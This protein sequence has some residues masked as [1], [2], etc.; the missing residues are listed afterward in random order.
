MLYRLLLACLIAGTTLNAAADAPI[1]TPL[2]APATQDAAA[3]RQYSEIRTPCRQ[4]NPLRNAYFGD[5]HVHTYLSLDAGLQGT[6]TTPDEAYRFAQGEPIGLQPWTDEGKPLRSLQLARPLDF[7]ALSDH[8]EFLGEQHICMTPG[9]EGY[10][11]WQC[12]FYRRWPSVAFI[13]MNM[14]TAWSAD[15]NADGEA[16]PIPRFGYCGKDGE[17]CREA[18]SHGWQ[19]IQQ[20]AEQHYDRSSDCQFTTF[21]GYE[22]SGGPKTENLHRNVIFRNSTVTA[23][24]V[25]YLDTPDPEQLW[26]RL[27]RECLTPGK[28]CDVLAIPH[29]SNVSNGRMFALTESN[30][31]PFSAEYV[32]LRHEMEPLVE[33]FQHK[34]DSECGL[35]SSDEQ[36]GF[37]KMPYNNL[38]AGRYNGWLTDKPSE[39][40]FVRDA[41]KQGL[42]VEQQL[43]T[44]PFQY[45]IIASTDTHLG[46]P[47]A[48]SESNFPGHGGAGYSAREGIRP[49][50]PDPV[51][52][53][54]GGLA[55][56]YAEENSRDALFNGMKRRE[57]YGTSGPRI[58]LRFFAGENYPE[59]LCNNADFVATGYAQGVPM[60]STLP[61]PANS[62]AF[63]VAAQADPG[64]SNEPG[65]PLQRIQII[66]GWIDNGIAHEKVFEVAGNPDNGATVDTNTCEP[67]GTGAAQLC[68]VWRD[69][70]FNPAQ[71]AFY[72]ARVLE[73]PSCRWSARQCVAAGVDCSQPDTVSK[74]Y[75]ACCT[76][77]APKIIQERA[78]SSPVWV[79]PAR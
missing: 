33:I 4:Y 27:K 77:E 57:T 12:G 41:L 15:R 58:G 5:T 61:A 63:A 75:E 73:N 56:V 6:R 76:A 26:A 14:R 69:P 71:P 54:P 68:A 20:A 67:Q 40:D 31:K 1:E 32:R 30:G 72:Y 13:F 45:G 22:W 66:K 39:S 8:S 29:N 7:V 64:A 62:P 38:I 42:K 21:V 79:S 10:D 23:L 16:L 60:G 18:A 53:N 44:N 47:G 74:G 34:G 52:Y 28:G 35:M 36:C 2:A 46:A 49:G 59:D 70:D 51:L 11:S 65:M 48:V 19:E 25:S 37:E 17:V 24:P 3:E 78:W 9:S 43:G 55:V 50:F